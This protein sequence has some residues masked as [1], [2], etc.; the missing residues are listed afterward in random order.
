[1]ALNYDAPRLLLRVGFS[2][3]IEDGGGEEA[4]QNEVCSSG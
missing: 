3:K 4:P 1:M 2:S